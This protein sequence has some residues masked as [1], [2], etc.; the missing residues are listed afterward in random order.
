[1]YRQIQQLQKRVAV[2]EQELRLEALSNENTRI[3]RQLSELEDQEKVVFLETLRQS[4]EISA[5]ED[6]LAKVFARLRVSNVKLFQSMKDQGQ[7][8]E[9]RKKEQHPKREKRRQS[10]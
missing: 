2:I 6:E 3:R 5:L 4:E 9:Q 8:G 1:M 7:F 10:I